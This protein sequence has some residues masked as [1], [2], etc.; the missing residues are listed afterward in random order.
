MKF[1][2]QFAHHGLKTSLLSTTIGPLNNRRPT[3]AGEKLLDFLFFD[4]NHIE[5]ATYENRVGRGRHKF[6]LLQFPLLSGRQYTPRG[7]S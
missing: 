5:L 1:T 3:N 6:E 2:A 4:W 7:I